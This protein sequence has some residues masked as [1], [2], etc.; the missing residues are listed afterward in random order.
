MIQLSTGSILQEGKYKIEK[1]LGQGGFG[2]T[3][4][5]EHTLL[6][7]KVA[8]KEFFYK[9][10]CNRDEST[11]HITLGT[12]SNAELVDRFLK[13]FV[14]EAQTISQFH[15]PNIVEIYDI[16]NENNT[17]Y[18]V[19]EYI[20]GPSL[21]D[22]VKQQGKLPETVATLYINKVADA[23]RCVHSHHINHLDVKPSNIML[24]KTDN[25]IILID[26]GT[27]KQYDV[28]TNIAPTTTTPVGI[29]AGFAPIEQYRKGGV[30]SFTPE[31][32]IYALGATLY[33]LLTGV[34]PPESI[35]LEDERLQ[36]LEL[37]SP[38]C[39]EVILKCMKVRKS[40]R[41]HSIDE[42]VA[43]F[44]SASSTV[45]CTPKDNDDDSTKVLEA[46]ETEE[47]E[48]RENKSD[49]VSP[50]ED[51]PEEQNNWKKYAFIALGVAVVVFGFIF[52]KG[53]S[54]ESTSKNENDTV[55]VEKANTQKE[56]AAETPNN[57]TNTTNASTTSATK[58]ETVKTEE[59]KKEETPKDNNAELLK[60][61]LN[62]GDYQTIQKLANQGF[63]PAY[64]PLAK[65][66][67]N[68]NEY[69][70]AARYAQKAKAA[71]QSGA[72]SVITALQNLGYYD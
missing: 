47:H 31:S 36:N 70:D 14:K 27:S 18:Y 29:S 15:H 53:G 71:G 25:E 2:I 9:D 49:P 50:T 28:E 41:P 66:Y 67:L 57:S 24:R 42:F 64:V 68:N 17:A 55:I 51:K 61:A 63:A 43:L 19:M 38:K 56:S 23:L 13:K 44:E 72:Q 21:N 54:D 59:V 16:F 26:F 32:D 34:T 58:K 8:I 62:K 30:S 33:K 7:K 6:G 45:N 20:E 52:F 12:Q 39:K 1:V 35:A 60:T 65:Y 48:Y 11:S 37:L 3:Y 10:Y 22:L 5:A 40:E 69:D 4:L 46:Y